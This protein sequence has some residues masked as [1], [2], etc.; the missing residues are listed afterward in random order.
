MERLEGQAIP[1]C[2]SS[3]VSLDGSLYKPEPR[4][5]HVLSVDVQEVSGF[6]PVLLRPKV[7]NSLIADQSGAG[8]GL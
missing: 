8:A 7:T 5:G 4:A 1:S 6:R 2:A 3:M